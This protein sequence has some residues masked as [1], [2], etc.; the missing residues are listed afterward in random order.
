MNSR[1]ETERPTSVACVR[2]EASDTDCP[3][4]RRH[5]LI[6]AL[7]TPPLWGTSF[8]LLRVPCLSGAPASLCS[9]YPASLVVPL[10]GARIRHTSFTCRPPRATRRSHRSRSG[11]WVGSATSPPSVAATSAGRRSSRPFLGG[12]W[13]PG[14]VWLGVGGQSDRSARLT[15]AASV[16]DGR[17]SAMAQRKGP[18]A[19]ERFTGRVG[20]RVHFRNSTE[21]NSKNFVRLGSHRAAVRFLLSSA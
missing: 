16:E 19:I 12:V 1:W 6:F 8:P 11:R 10:V 18:L 20:F 15:A 3:C 7:S 21:G 2:L 14:D 13:P 9:E 5:Q 17:C 4:D